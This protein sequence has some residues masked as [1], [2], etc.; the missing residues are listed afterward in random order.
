MVRT[1]YV[2]MLA[3]GLTM[4]R[5]LLYKLIMRRLLLYEITLVENVTA[6]N[7]TIEDYCYYRN[8]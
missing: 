5:M 2:R 8:R 7:N 1:E 6:W 3:Y 4:W